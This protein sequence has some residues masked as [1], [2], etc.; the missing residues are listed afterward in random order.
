M[1][2]KNSLSFRMWYFCAVISDET[3]GFYMDNTPKIV[4]SKTTTKAFSFALHPMQYAEKLD[5]CMRPY[6]IAIYLYSGYCVELSLRNFSLSLFWFYFDSCFCR[7]R[8]NKYN[9]FWFGVKEMAY[10]KNEIQFPKRKSIK[11]N[12]Y[13][14][15]CTATEV[16]TKL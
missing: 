14:R 4:I 6:S 5:L 11:M 7:I 15:I 12:C 9:C 8:N 3:I 1:R 13:K 10:L 16:T 2:Y